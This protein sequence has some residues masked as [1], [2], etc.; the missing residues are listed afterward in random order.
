MVGSH[1]Q[2]KSEGARDGGVAGTQRPKELCEKGFFIQGL[3]TAHDN[4]GIKQGNQF[5]D[6]TL[7]PPLSPA[8]APQ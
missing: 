6:L 5:S 8:G 1:Y 4:L 7:L 3:Q 2:P